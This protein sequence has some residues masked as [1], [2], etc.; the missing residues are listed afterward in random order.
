M[1]EKRAKEKARKERE[2]AELREK[3]LNGL[4]KREDQVW[5]QV[6]ELIGTKRPTD[7]DSA[8]QL[9]VD[10][11]DLSTK[12]KN[13]KPFQEKLQRVREM[14]SRKPSFMESLE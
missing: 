8:V 10:L 13:E 11:R 4:V 6:D 2:R 1:A 9:L 12:R 14:H 5:N 3:Y 7:Y